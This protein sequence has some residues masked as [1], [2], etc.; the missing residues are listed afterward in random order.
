[1]TKTALTISSKNYSSLCDSGFL[2]CQDDLAAAG[3]FTVEP[4]S[5]EV[6]MGTTGQVFLYLSPFRYPATACGILFS[7]SLETEHQ[8][9][10]IGTPFDSGGIHRCFSRSEPAEPA[11]TFLGRLATYRYLDMHQVIAEALDLAPALAAAI[12]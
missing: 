8:V 12:R 10:G 9:D 4:D 7:P 1:M 2:A 11:T 5:A 3:A 6:A